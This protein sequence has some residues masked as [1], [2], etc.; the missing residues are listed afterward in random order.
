[1]GYIVCLLE[2]HYVVFALHC[3]CLLHC[4]VF[5]Y[6]VLCFKLHCVVL[7]LHGIVLYI[8]LLCLLAL[9]MLCFACVTL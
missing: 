1:M 6:I 9:H 8:T 3:A 7:A 2:L 5:A 4:V